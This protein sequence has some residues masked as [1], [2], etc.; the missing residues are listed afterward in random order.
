[1]NGHLGFPMQKNIRKH[2]KSEVFKRGTGLDTGNWILVGGLLRR[3]H[4]ELRSL[5]FR[6][7]SR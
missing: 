7:Y 4:S 3:V 6:R 2:F 5:K 1:M